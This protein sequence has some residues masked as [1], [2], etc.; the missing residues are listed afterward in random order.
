MSKHHTHT[1]S[2]QQ[3]HTRAPASAH[4]P[5]RQVRRMPRRFPWGRILGS[6]GLVLLVSGT[7]F[8]LAQQNA[9]LSDAQGLVRQ[10][11]PATNVRLASSQG[12]P[13]SL[14]QYRGKKVVLYFYEGATCGSCQQQ[15]IQLQQ[16]I[17]AQR[18][19]TVV[20]A[21]SVDPGMTSSLLARQL[22]LSF[23]ILADV[24]H[25][26]GSA[27]RDYHLVTAGM[28]MGPVDNHAIF[29]LDAQGTVRWVKL[30]AD[31]MYVPAANVT[32]ALDQA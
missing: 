28:D 17:A 23:P 6:I 24:D 3:M 14:A 18:K 21:A 5:H 26:L 30:A 32:A 15:L 19:D 12:H 11:A 9:P 8:W 22:K 16:A 2:R 13:I 25:K 20:V 31:T 7:L 27:F 1:M 29:V 4:K 10:A